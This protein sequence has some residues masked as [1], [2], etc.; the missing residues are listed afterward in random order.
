MTHDLINLPAPRSWRDIPQP[1]KPRAMSASGRWRLFA[2]GLR[3]TFVLTLIGSFAWGVWAIARSLR[4]LPISDSIAAQKIPMRPPQLAT[5][6]VHTTEWLSRTLALP[7]GVTLMEL[8]L[9][10]LRDRLLGDGQVLTARLTRNFPDRLAVQITERFPVARAMTEWAGRQLPLLVAGDGTIFAG[11]GYDDELLRTLP[12]LDGVTISR[13]GDGF[14]PIAGME[15]VTELLGKARLEAEHLYRS[16]QIVSLA[17]LELDREL[18][19]RT[20]EGATIVF[21]AAADFFPQ[22]AKLDYMWEQIAK[23]AGPL[24]I[25]L[26]LGREVPVR[27]ELPVEPRP[28]TFFRPAAAAPAYSFFPSTPSKT[29]REL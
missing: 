23:A 24:R 26:S 4:G 13:R 21:N 29:K 3:V 27:I 17:R 25:D 6:G 7:A 1:V 2:A 15:A 12:W 8:N 14:S 22:L 28:S 19:V 9:E 11:E 5:D 20:S 10:K 18:E 16:W